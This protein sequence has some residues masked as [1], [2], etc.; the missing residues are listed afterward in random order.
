M[1][2]LLFADF[3]RHGALGIIRANGRY[4]RFGEGEPEVVIR[5]K[6]SAAEKLRDQ[7]SLKT[8]VLRDGKPASIPT[9]E[10][11]PGDVVLLS[12]A[13]SS[14]DMFESYQQRGE[15]FREAVQ[16]WISAGKEKG[17]VHA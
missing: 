11:V 1:L 5:F 13:C 2:H 7:V 6:D 4:L 16:N 8:N 3:F 17:A 9:E 15:Q 10:V 12:P 14:F